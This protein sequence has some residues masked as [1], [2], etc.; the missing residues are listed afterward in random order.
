M[1]PTTSPDE[2]PRVTARHLRRPDSICPLRLAKE[3]SGKRGAR[4]P[5][6]G[7]EVSNRMTADARQAHTE[8]RVAT[9]ADFPVPDDLTVEQQRVYATSASWY[10]ALFGA[11][12]AC[13]ADVDEW[14]TTDEPTGTVLVGQVGIA[15]DC[16]DGR[17]QLR[18]LSVSRSPRPPD[19]VGRAFALVRLASWARGRPVEVVW[20]DL[21]SGR[22]DVDVVDV[23]SGLPRARDLLA[24]RIDLLAAHADDPRPWPG[25]DCADCR[26]I[27]ECGAHR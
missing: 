9:E 7:Y 13:V 11:T 14:S 6:A 8:M 22:V 10:L 4:S 2:P 26:F 18:S 3:R 27:A 12:A 17:A 20:A 25:Q 19:Q 15:V 16:A 1:D 23:E 21:V 24:P 5:S